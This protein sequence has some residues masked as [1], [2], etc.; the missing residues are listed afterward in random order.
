LES[1]LADKDALNLMARRSDDPEDTP[2][3]AVHGQTADHSPPI[4]QT[5]TL[6]PSAAVNATLAPLGSVYYF[7]DYE[8]LEEIA[9]FG[10][11]HGL[12]APPRKRGR[13]RTVFARG[14]PPDRR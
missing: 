10:M 6:P 9:C 12:P 5:A 11:G 4:D 3:L 1:F 14:G 13:N 2:P 8:L 7:G